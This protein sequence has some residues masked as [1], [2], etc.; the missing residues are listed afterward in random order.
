MTG[1]SK[2][3]DWETAQRRNCPAPMDDPN[4]TP[5][6]HCVAFEKMEDHENDQIPDRDE[7]HNAR[8]FER[9]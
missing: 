5:L 8:V 6:M 1:V 9:V 2:Y 7:G 3:N 4:R